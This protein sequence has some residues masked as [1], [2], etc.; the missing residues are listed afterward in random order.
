MRNLRALDRFELQRLPKSR[1]SVC[2]RA[3]LAVSIAA[4]IGG[5]LLLAFKADVL[6]SVRVFG[7]QVFSVGGWTETLVLLVPLGLTSLGVTIA[8][9]AGFW[10][11]GGEGQLLIGA[12]V[13]VLAAQALEG[14]GLVRFLTIPLLLLAAFAGGALV[15]IVA[16]AAKTWRGADEV[17]VTLLTNFVALY[18]VS[19]LVSGPLRDIDTMWVQSAPLAEP[20]RFERLPGLGRLNTSVFLFMAVASLLIHLERRTHCNTLLEVLESNPRAL[21]PTGR[22]P[23]GVLLLTSA[24]SGGLCGLA[25]WAEVA[26]TQ[27]RLIEDL[28]PG[29]GY[30][31]VVVA[32]AAGGR[33]S[34]AVWIAL[35]VAVLLNG[36]DSSTRVAGVPVYVGEIIMGLA[37]ISYLLIEK[38]SDH[39]IRLRR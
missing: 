36:I 19:Y 9:K 29:Y 31:A 39:R 13:G 38:L 5:L 16:G 6:E 21:V 20:L 32:V 3:P 12:L 14:A 23:A 11:I 17:L 37:L 1:L 28:S 25:G 15:G 10:N 18:F 7:R 8:R 2:Y 26:G 24:V 33:C 34:R 4:L 30:F 35:L 27:Y 22:R